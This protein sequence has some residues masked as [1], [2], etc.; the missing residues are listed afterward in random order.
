MTVDAYLRP[1]FG[2]T[3][4]DV[5]LQVPCQLHPWRTLL[6][7]Q[8]VWGSPLGPLQGSAQLLQIGLVLH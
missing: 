3:V 5:V 4:Q 1:V 2:N 6:L 8:G 7:W